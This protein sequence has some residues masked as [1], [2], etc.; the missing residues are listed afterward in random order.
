MVK[1]RKYCLVLG[2]CC[3]RETQYCWNLSF[4]SILHEGTSPVLIGVYSSSNI[5]TLSTSDESSHSSQLG[6]LKALF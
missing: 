3:V 5:M 6:S 1:G 2:A 4:T